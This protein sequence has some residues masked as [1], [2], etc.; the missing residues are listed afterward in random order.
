MHDR[1]GV[2]SFQLRIP[3]AEVRHALAGSLIDAY[4]GNLPSERFQYQKSVYLALNQGDVPQ[5]IAAIKRLFASIPWRNFTNNDLLNAEGYYASVLYAFFA[6]LNASIIAEDLTNHGQV[7][8]TVLLEG[9]TYVVEIKL[10]KSTEQ[11]TNQTP[12]Q[13]KNNA[14]LKQII[15]RRYS[16]KYRQQPGKG[17]YE[18]GLVFGGEARN[19]VQADWRQ[20]D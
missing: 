7:D 5:L 16:E 10:D 6:S 3:N 20:V 14:A 17:L 19:L 1:F 11:M 4:T 2:L 8:L 18:V 15:E 13:S 12:T 9:Y